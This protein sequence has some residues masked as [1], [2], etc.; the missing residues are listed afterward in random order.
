MAKNKKTKVKPVVTA[1]DDDDIVPVK[2]AKG[3]RGSDEDDELDPTKPR[4]RYD[5]YFG[6][7]LLTTL[8]LIGAAALLYMDQ[9]DLN[10]P[11][12]AGFNPPSVTA[13]A[14]GFRA[15]KTN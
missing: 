1:D 14:L 5:V 6:L 15:A 2:K 12:N 13:G 11:A 10:S 7:T 8:I 4:A 3:G 9:E